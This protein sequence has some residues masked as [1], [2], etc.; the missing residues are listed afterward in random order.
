MLT[1]SLDLNELMGY[2][3][4]FQIWIGVMYEKITIMMTSSNGKGFR[5]TGPLCELWGGG[6]GVPPVTGGFPSQRA[7][8]VGFGV[9]FDIS[10]NKQ[11]SRRWFETP[12]RYGSSL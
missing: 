9:S 3:N 4:L 1:T 2:L 12:G 11:S 10:L 5:V 6:G 7:S 8:N